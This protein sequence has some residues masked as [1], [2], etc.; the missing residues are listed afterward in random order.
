M[1]SWSVAGAERKGG[2][3]SA[4]KE[5]WTFA[6][7]RVGDLAQEDPTCRGASRPVRYNYGA[8]ALEPA[9]Y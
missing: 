3:L 1:R 8:S 7:S 2:R 9:K 4:R 6:R 5:R